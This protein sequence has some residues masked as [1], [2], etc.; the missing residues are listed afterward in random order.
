M[1]VGWG[2]ESA[3]GDA[4][5][6]HRCGAF[7]A[8]FSPIHRASARLLA[9]ARCLGDAAIHGHVGQFEADDAIIGLKHQF[10]QCV[11]H[12]QSNPLVAPTA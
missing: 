5:R 1:A 3:Y 9:A 12:P 10:A 11:H 8:L 6:I 7:D 4:P 2:R